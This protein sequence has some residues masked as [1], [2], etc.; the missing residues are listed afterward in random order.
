MPLYDQ[1][2]MV[3]L[4]SEHRKSISRLHALSEVDR[5]IFLSDPDKIGSA[6]YHFIVAIETCI[7]ICNHVISRNGFRVPEDYG[8]TFKVLEEVGAFDSEFAEQL[9]NMAKFRNRL[10]HLY[11]EVD[12]AQLYDILHGRLGDFKKFLNSI[13]EFLGWQNLKTS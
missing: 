7:D 5:E 4:V 11:W 9:K 2:R 10:V 12:D 13:A 1:E 3:K 8:D 6:K